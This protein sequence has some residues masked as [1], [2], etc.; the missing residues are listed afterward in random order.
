MFTIPSLVTFSRGPL[1]EHSVRP[2][3]K[4]MENHLSACLGAGL[5]TAS[6]S[7]PLSGYCP[8]RPPK[9]GVIVLSENEFIFCQ[10]NRMG[11]SLTRIQL[12]HIS[13]VQNSRFIKH[14]LL[15]VYS[16]G[17]IFEFASRMNPRDVHAFLLLLSSRLKD[18]H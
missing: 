1:E 10:K 4:A 2:R 6:L 11:E 3:P 13:A 9:Y 16:P 5:T 8:G 15:K 12:S 17:F 18:I 7:N 14:H